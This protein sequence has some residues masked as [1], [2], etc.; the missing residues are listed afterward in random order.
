MDQIN[1]ILFCMYV[2]NSN[3]LLI[4]R[5]PL[6]KISVLN[7]YQVS[8][9]PHEYKN[10]YYYYYYLLLLLSINIGLPLPYLGWPST[11]EPEVRIVTVQN[12]YDLS[13]HQGEVVSLLGIVIG[14]CHIQGVGLKDVYETFFGLLL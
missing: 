12:F 5:C 6:G 10:Y 7:T 8:C 13:F 4:P 9:N 1:T 2:Y 11:T 14:Y 3:I